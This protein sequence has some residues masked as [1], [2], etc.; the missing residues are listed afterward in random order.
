MGKA[1]VRNRARRLLRE[2][3]RLHQHDFQEPVAMVLI[4]RASIVGKEFQQVERD[5]LS[6]LR[7]GKLLK[8]NE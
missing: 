2:A 6:V 7:Q 4:G 1:N 5:F 3:F 8:R